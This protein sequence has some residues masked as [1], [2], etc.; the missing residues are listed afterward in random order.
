MRWE[1]KKPI[2]TMQIGTFTYPPGTG[3]SKNRAGISIL[4]EEGPDAREINAV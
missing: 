4:D 1:K 2:H 3:I